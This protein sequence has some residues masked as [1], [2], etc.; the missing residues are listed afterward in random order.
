MGYVEKGETISEGPSNPHEILR[1]LG[2]NKLANYIG[3][4][5]QDVYRLQ[6]V[7][8]NDKHIEVILRQ[9]LRKVI[10]VSPGDSNYLVGEQVDINDAESINNKLYNE[11]KNL[12]KFERLLLGITKA[13]LATKSFLSAA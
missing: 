10:I 2:V 13:S 6:G 11:N 12:I 5:V 7:K 9:M 3:K 4:E 1:L 8:I